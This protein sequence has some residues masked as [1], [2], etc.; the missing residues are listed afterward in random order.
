MSGAFLKVILKWKTKL[1]FLLSHFFV[2][3][4]KILLLVVFVR[5]FLALNVLPISES[6]IEMKN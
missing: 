1:K 6:Y 5:S 4:Q 2:V 3:P